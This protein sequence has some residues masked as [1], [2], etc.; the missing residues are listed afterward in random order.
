[1][2]ISELIA[3]LNSYQDKWGDLPVYVASDIWLNFFYAPDFSKRS[4]V[5]AHDKRND[6]LAPYDDRVSYEYTADEN[7]DKHFRSV[8]LVPPEYRGETVL[9]LWIDYDDPDVKEDV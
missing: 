5:L 6:E 2:R 8:N 9:G 4:Q 3:L 7:V 1:M